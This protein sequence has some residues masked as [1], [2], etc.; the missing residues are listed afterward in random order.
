MIKIGLWPRLLGELAG[1]LEHEAHG[2]ER[3]GVRV[4][5]PPELHG[6]RAARGQRLDLRGGKDLSIQPLVQTLIQPSS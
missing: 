4:V 2:G 3:V 5:P 1:L 6:D